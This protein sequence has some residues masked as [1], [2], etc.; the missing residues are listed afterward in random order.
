MRDV[1]LLC[2][3]KTDDN[4]K[5]RRARERVLWRGEMSELLPENGGNSR[6]RVTSVSEGGMTRFCR[7]RNCIFTNARVMEMLTFH[8]LKDGDLSMFA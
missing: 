5:R 1:S 7:N 4:V 3:G 8:H 6:G 2:H